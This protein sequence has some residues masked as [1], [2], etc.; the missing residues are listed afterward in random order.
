LKGYQY[1]L[2]FSGEEVLPADKNSRN[3]DVRFPLGSPECVHVFAILHSALIIR[4][5]MSQH[6]Q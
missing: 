4:N 2:I 6:F 1:F 3:Q 5:T